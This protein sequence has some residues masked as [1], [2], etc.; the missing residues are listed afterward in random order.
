MAKIELRFPFMKIKKKVE[1]RF[2]I[3]DLVVEKKTQRNQKRIGEI[4]FVRDGRKRKLEMVEL[5]KHDLRPIQKGSLDGPKIFSLDENACKKLNLFRFKEKT[6]LN[7][8]I[9][10]SK[11]NTIKNN[12]RKAKWL[13]G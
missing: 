11:I 13:Q 4:I 3:W 6:N 7:F 8:S 10:T 12:T 9:W 5:N 2:S 1:E